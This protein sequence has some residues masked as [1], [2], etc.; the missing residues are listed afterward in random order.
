LEIGE[1]FNV[2]DKFVGECRTPIRKVKACAILDV[3]G[4]ENM[5]K[6]HKLEVLSWPKPHYLHA[7]IK[8]FPVEKAQKEHIAHMLSE[9][10]SVELRERN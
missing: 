6:N 4:I 5:E 8:P 1:M 2:G 7:N 9:M 3:N 10:A